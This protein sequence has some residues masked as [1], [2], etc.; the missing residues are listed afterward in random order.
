MCGVGRDGGGRGKTQ[1]PDLF[2]LGKKI[3]ESFSA[4]DLGRSVACD[5]ADLGRLCSGSS[6]VLAPANDISEASCPLQ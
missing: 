5:S 2:A 4:D 6:A 1:E 3:R